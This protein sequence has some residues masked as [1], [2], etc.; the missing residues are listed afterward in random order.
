LKFS[1]FESLVGQCVYV[2]ATPADYELVKSE[3]I[4]VEQLIRPTGL[5]DPEIE[6]RPTDG[7]I[8]NLLDEIE[9]CT[10]RHEKVMVTTLTKRMAEELNS[11]FE[12]LG[13]RC[14]YI[15]SDVDTL[16]RIQ[17]LDDMHADVFDVLIGVNL[18][19]EGLDMPEVALVAIMDA[20]K[21][22]FL[23]STRS[24]TQTAGRAARNANGRVIMY[25]DRITDSM[26]ATI[27]ETNRRRSI[28]IEYNKRHS[29]T[30][31][32]TTRSAQLTLGR[33]AQNTEYQPYPM[34]GY[35]GLMAADTNKPYITASELEQMIEQRRIA[36]ED[37]AKK[38]DFIAAAQFR[39]QMYDLQAKLK[40][41]KK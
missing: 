8:D 7:Q 40:D 34:A 38:L 16:E 9:L 17:I 36:M 41:L 24:L 10:G 26:R 1:E 33:T 28:Q 18:L 30:P 31:R 4:V 35:N 32:S 3:G 25:A 14:R 20:D 11:Y 27:A 23:R 19:R 6:V 12:R 13:I 21:E 22:G 2:S 15:H 5:L 29:I 39:D 37:A